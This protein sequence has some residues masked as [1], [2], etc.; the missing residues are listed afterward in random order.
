MSCI[1]GGPVLRRVGNSDA[2]MM[3]PDVYM[4]REHATTYPLVKLAE[5][6]FVL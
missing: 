3:I 4:R 2:I 5:M 6:N 1:T